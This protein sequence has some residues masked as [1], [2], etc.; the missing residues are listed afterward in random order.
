MFPKPTGHPLFCSLIFAFKIKKPTVDKR[1]T[2]VGFLITLLS[3][4]CRR[5]CFFGALHRALFRLFADGC[6]GGGGA[7]GLEFLHA[8]GGVDQLL[9]SGIERVAGIADFNR[10]F[11]LGRADVKYVAARARNLGVGIVLGV[12]VFFH[13]EAIVPYLRGERKGAGSAVPA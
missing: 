7:A 3:F 11:F 1:L 6:F 4:L 10:Q 12:N 8:A 9:F 2:A 13:N 5:G